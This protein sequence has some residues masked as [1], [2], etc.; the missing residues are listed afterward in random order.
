MPNYLLHLW[1]VPPADLPLTCPPPPPGEP[2]DPTG[3]F[4]PAT[5]HGA[6]SAAGWASLLLVLALVCLCY[7][8]TSGSLG[9]RFMR[10]WVLFLALSGAAALGVAV[11][12]LR[13]WPTRA[14]AGSC[15]TNPEPFLAALPWSE[16]LGR[17]LAGAVWGVLVFA[18]LSLVLTRTAGLFPWSRGLFHHRGCPYPRLSPFGE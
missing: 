17:G 14:L 7:L 2:A 12:V 1:S 18:L 15:E 13:T 3:F 5:V 6:Y 10:R 16:V 11:L 9:P 8:W 4:D